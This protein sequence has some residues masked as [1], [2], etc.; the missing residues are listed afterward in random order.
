MRLLVA[1]CVR[2]CVSVM[3]SGEIDN[4]LPQDK[5]TMQPSLGKGSAL[6]LVIDAIISS[7]GD[8]VCLFRLIT[9][10]IDYLCHPKLT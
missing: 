6:M 7:A 3:P 9:A 2:V 5:A 10:L 1:V 8:Y 4:H